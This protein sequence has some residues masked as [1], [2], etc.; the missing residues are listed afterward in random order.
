MHTVPADCGRGC[1]LTASVAAAVDEIGW[2]CAERRAVTDV[3][4]F[5]LTEQVNSAHIMLHSRTSHEHHCSSSTLVAAVAT[6]AARA[7]LP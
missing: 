3:V 7:S 2:E 6:V 5:V 1:I 4:T